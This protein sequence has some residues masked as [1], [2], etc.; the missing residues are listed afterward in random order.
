MAHQA[1]LQAR[2]LEWGAIPFSL[3]A[4]MV[5]YLAAMRETGFNPWV[6]KIP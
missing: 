3:V 2:I 4:Q 6:R 5:T 1:L